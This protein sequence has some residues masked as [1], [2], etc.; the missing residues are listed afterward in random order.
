[1]SRSA[2]APTGVLDL[3]PA[4]WRILVDRVPRIAADRLAR[5]IRSGGFGQEG[6]RARVQDLRSHIRP[7]IRDRARMEFLPM[8]DLAPDGIEPF[9]HFD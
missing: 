7:D 3:A 8:L 6:L 2:S 4:Y 1:M 5:D 9:M